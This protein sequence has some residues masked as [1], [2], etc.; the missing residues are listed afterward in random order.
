[1]DAHLTRMDETLA[2]EETLYPTTR[3]VDAINPRRYWAFFIPLTYLLAL[4]VFY[5]LRIDLGEA[6]KDSLF[7][8]SIALICVVAAFRVHRRY[9][10]R[11]RRLIA[12]MLL[13]SVLAGWQIFDLVI[14]RTGSATI[15]GFGKALSPALSEQDGLG[16]YVPRFPSPEILCHSMYERYYG[17]KFI[18]ITLEIKRNEI[19]PV[20]GG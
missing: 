4:M 15:V 14:L 1:M 8:G 13:C 20:C 7:Y 9:G 17:N 3:T 2:S 12:V 11:G 10:K 16:W 19:W 5:P 6:F 18:A